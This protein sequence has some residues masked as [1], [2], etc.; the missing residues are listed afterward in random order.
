MPVNFFIIIDKY[1]LNPIIH[2]VYIRPTSKELAG[3][4]TDPD[5][6]SKVKSPEDQKWSE[7]MGGIQS[8][9]GANMFSAGHELG[10]NKGKEAKRN[11]LF[12]KAAGLVFQNPNSGIRVEPTEAR[13]R[14]HDYTGE[15]TVFERPHR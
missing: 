13:R 4:S 2:S 11:G 1:L 3:M 5:R 7:E 9:D 15:D 6:P 14:R 12:R 10:G 8:R